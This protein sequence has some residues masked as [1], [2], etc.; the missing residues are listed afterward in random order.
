MDF[1][2]RFLRARVSKYRNFAPENISECNIDVLT[3]KKG[4]KYEKD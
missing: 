1:F 3:E 2:A 4:K